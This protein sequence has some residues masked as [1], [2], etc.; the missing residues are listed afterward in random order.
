M[1]ITVTPN[2]SLDRTF[3]ADS[4]VLGHINRAH[5]THVDAGGKGINVTRALAANGV[6]SIA[7]FPAGG[8]DGARL[9]D[10]LRALSIQVRPVTIDGETRGNITL[11]DAAGITTKINAA[12]AALTAEALEQLL[13]ALDD[14]LSAAR[15]A[16]HEALVV[17]AG[18]LPQGAEDSFYTEVALRSAHY[19]ARTVLD[20]SGTPLT[21]AV[22]A[23]GLA[24]VKPNDDEL[25]ELVG[26][27]LVTVGDVLDAAREVMANGIDEV[28]VSLGAHGALLVA[29]EDSW[30]AGGPE[31]VPLSTVGAGDTTLAGYLSASFAAHSEPS[32]ALRTA[33]AWGRAAV[34][35]PGSAAPLPSDIDLGP[36][37][38]TT[39]PSRHLTLKEL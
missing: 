14:E 29:A 5:S 35:L 27:E 39:N 1:I 13:S 2:P 8:A 24:L 19:G 3:E 34:L 17:G 16:G 9:V 22:A 37:A 28:L 38:S 30:W 7:V 4:I 11:V 18:S 32:R 25:A 6:P 26:R 20:T 21:A 36:V 15:A 23:G 12:G 10:E 33:V 31:L